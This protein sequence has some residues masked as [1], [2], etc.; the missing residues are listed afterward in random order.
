MIL[1]ICSAKSFCILHQADHVTSQSPSSHVCAGTGRQ[2]Q[3]LPTRAPRQS[4]H[5]LHRMERALRAAEG[6][7]LCKCSLIAPLLLLNFKRVAMQFRECGSRW[8]TEEQ[9]HIDFS[10]GECG[11]WL[12]NYL[13]SPPVNAVLV[14][15]STKLII[16]FIFL[17]IFYVIKDCLNL[18][19]NKQSILI[20]KGKKKFSLAYKERT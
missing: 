15:Q 12:C 16:N 7:F 10:W 1:Q 14:E 20:F 17:K 19:L 13:Y 9:S 6:M 5:G 2:S 8:S 3:P 11:L 18:F 4:Q